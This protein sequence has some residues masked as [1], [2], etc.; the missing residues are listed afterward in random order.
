[1]QSGD[2]EVTLKYVKKCWS[3][4][5][6]DIFYGYDTPL[7]LNDI[8]LAELFATHPTRLELALNFSGFYYKILNASEKA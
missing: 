2:G 4:I 6:S 5:A 1:M 3:F 7:P 8:A